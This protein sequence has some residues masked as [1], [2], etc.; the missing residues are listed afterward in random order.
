MNPTLNFSR[1]LKLLYGCILP[2]SSEM[3][4]GTLTSRYTVSGSRL[5][6]L[7]QTLAKYATEVVVG[8]DVGIV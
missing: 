7:S 3:P 2:T 1:R 4:D 6:F 5:N 8:W